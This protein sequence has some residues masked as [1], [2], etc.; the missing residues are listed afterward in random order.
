VLAH[1]EVGLPTTSAEG[2]SSSYESLIT[3]HFS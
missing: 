1:C 2:S 3:S